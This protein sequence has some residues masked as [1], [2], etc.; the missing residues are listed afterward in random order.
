M[1]IFKEVCNYF[2]VKLVNKYMFIIYKINFT[3]KYY[4]DFQDIRH[5]IIHFHILD[6]NISDDIHSLGVTLLF[7]GSKKRRN[8]H[9]HK[10]I[11]NRTL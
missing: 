2:S 7:L 5:S 9:I 6:T 1:C 3:N 10:Y 4:L 11:Y 8:I